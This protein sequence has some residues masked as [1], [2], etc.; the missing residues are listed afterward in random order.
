[1][2]HLRRP[3]FMPI[4]IVATVLLLGQ[5]LSFVLGTEEGL[6]NTLAAAS[7]WIAVLSYLTASKQIPS[8]ERP[9]ETIAGTAGSAATD[10]KRQRLS[11][12]VQID[13]GLF[14]GLALGC[15]AGAAGALAYHAQ[16]PDRVSLPLAATEIIIFFAVGFTL[17]GVSCQL[18]TALFRHLV[19]FR[20]YSAFLFNELTGSLAGGAVVGVIVGPLLGWYFGQ[21]MADRAFA[22]PKLIWSVTGPSSV[23]MALVFSFIE[24][25][26]RL[27]SRLRC[28][29]IA[30]LFGFVII[31][32]GLVLIETL[33]LNTR[34]FDLWYPQFP[35]SSS[36]RQL[37]LG[38][39]VYTSF[40]TFLMSLIIGASHLI[41]RLVN[42]DSPEPST[43]AQSKARHNAGA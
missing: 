6:K 17:L 42:S 35:Y 26:K 1:M 12:R 43:E 10:V 11:F 39:A 3:L 31:A 21:Y 2:N 4:I 22:D 25:D 30:A 32:V 7:L 33:K 41:A 13:G 23:I 27:W 28:T 8:S 15:L 40:I 37:L 18:F 24:T 20:G 29:L 38:G 19:H 34:F 14:G 9:E 5:F 16:D 36:S